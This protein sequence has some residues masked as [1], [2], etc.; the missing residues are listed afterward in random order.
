VTLRGASVAALAGLSAVVLLTA[1]CGPHA[2][3]AG[4]LPLERNAPILYV[5]LGDSTVEGVGASRADA[6]YV[7]QLHARLRAVYPNARVLNLGK[8]GA[9]SDDVVER[10]LARAVAA[11]PQL[12]TLS[13]G[14]NDIE[15]GMKPDRYE[16]N[17]AKI[18]TRLTRETD[19]VVVVTLIPDM[20]VTPKFRNSPQRDAIADAVRR[21]NERLAEQARLVRAGVVDI[22]TASQREVP[23]RPELLAGDGYHPSDLGYA[24]W[25]ELMWPTVQ[26]RIAG[27]RASDGLSPM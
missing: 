8:G 4:A 7:G 19:A 25:A 5:A 6:T 10:Q 26:A 13:I 11:R 24:R 14:P 23:G 2:M 1:A 16:Y 17:V 22:Y 21:F 15:A 3:G 12:A 18:L 20:T 27:T 9:T